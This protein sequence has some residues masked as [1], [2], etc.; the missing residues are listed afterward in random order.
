MTI[1]NFRSRY[2]GRP[3]SQKPQELFDKHRPKIEELICT[4]FGVRTSDIEFPELTASSTVEGEIIIKV[5][6]GNAL[7]ICIIDFSEDYS[8]VENLVVK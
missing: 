8:E 2:E 3:L 7:E 5:F 6:I 4:R 1:E